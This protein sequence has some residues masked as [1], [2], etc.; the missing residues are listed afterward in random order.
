MK[1]TY[2]YIFAAVIVSCA[3]SAMAQGLNSGYFTNDFK[4]RHDLNPAYGNDQSYFALPFA[5]NINVKMM[6]NFG[7]EDIV[8]DNPQPTNGKKKTSFMNPY[9]SASDA[10]SNF[11]DNNKLNG[12]VNI[13]LFSMGFKGMGGYNTL[14]INVRANVGAHLPYELFEFAKNTGNKT[15]DIGNIG[16]DAKSFTELAFGHSHSINDHLRIG[17]KVKALFGVGRG[18]FD[19]KNVKANLVGDE[20]SI[21]GDGLASVSMKGF[22]YK[23]KTK[24]YNA[25][26]ETYE[27]VNGADVDGAGLG[28]FGL[29]VDL[30]AIYKIN[31]DFTVSAALLDLGFINWTNDVQ[32]VNKSKS[33][34][35]SGFHDTSVGPDGTN[36]M[37]DQADKYSDQISDFINLQDNGDQGSKTTS[38][39]ATL[40]LGCEYTFPYYR[41]LTFGFLES[42]R[43][44]G[45]YSWTEGRLSAN[46]A[47]V[48]WI[49]GGINLAV[50]TFGTSFGWILNIHP[51]GINIYV[52][53]DHLVGKCSKEYI[54]LNSKASLTA[55]VSFAW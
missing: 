23:T 10:L 24:K 55:G 50:G 41:K 39:G 8:L 46:V 16:I 31:Q 19:F 17:A 7:Y 40:N 28:G 43:I 35:F 45:D 30:G 27:R 33:F 37:D 11:K 42:T 52:G 48:K 4:N 2:K 21:T 14:E 36:K 3:A 9:I 44:N 1:F 26:S 38:I 22:K 6:G 53:M 29:G 51:K 47:P 18:S 13:G 34:T 25:S 54:P 49:D 15:Y 32:A 12:Q 5:G 20:W